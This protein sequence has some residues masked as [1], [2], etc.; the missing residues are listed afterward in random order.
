MDESLRAM[1][2]QHQ[3]VAPAAIAESSMRLSHAGGDVPAFE[4]KPA[5]GSPRGAVVVVQEAF[6]VNDHIKSIARRFAAVGYQAVAPHLFHRTG[7]PVFGYE[8]EFARLMPHMEAL[9]DEEQLSD[10]DAVLEHLRDAGWVDGQIG[11]V[12][13]CMGGRT[14]FLVS[15]RRTLGAGV[16]FYGGNI[17]SSNHDN[18]PA[19]I[20]TLPALRTP[21][22]GLFGDEDRTISIEDV[23]RLR[24]EAASGATVDVEIRSYADAGH[25]FHCDARPSFAPEAAADA[26]DRT[27]AWFD[28]YL[29]PG[30]AGTNGRKS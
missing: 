16:G 10:V 20:E 19:L 30:P 9:R 23:E 3:V 12:G 8:G 14:T 21:W 13:F 29:Q 26:W 7:D 6:G 17:V 18:M 22:L 28:R 2:G 27:L 15:T 25:G 24:S 1:D 11:I 4:A 5:D